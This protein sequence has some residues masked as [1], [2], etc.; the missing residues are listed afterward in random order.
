MAWPLG[1]FPTV[2]FQ[3][4]P[5]DLLSIDIRDTDRHKVFQVIEARL[6]RPGRLVH[7]P[8]S[9]PGDVREL[10]QLWKLV[11][12]YRWIVIEPLRSPLGRFAIQTDDDS[13]VWVASERI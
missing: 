13:V 1:Q 11:I 9:D 3:G 7:R 8:P 2:C 5:Q 6:A 4:S 10:V 12:G